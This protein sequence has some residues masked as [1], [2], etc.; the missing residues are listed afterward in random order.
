M[1]G[2]DALPV[3][4]EKYRLR[5]AC[6]VT[7]SKKRKGMSADEKQRTILSIYH[8]RCEPFN[9]KELENLAAKAGVV[10]QTVKD[11]NQSLIDD[12]L[13]CSDKIGAANIFWS[14]PRYISISIR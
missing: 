4:E 11:V 12:S 9:L 3:N 7:M 6:I 13:V 1:I 5:S 14:F 2:S 10:Q 8:E